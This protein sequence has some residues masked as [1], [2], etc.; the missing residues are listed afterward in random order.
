MGKEIERKFLVNDKINKVLSKVNSKHCSQTYLASD[1]EKVV[2]VRILGK[3]GFLTIKSKVIGI[4]R[5]EF[6][7]EIPLDEANKMIDLFGV[8]VI[9]KK[10][11]LIPIKN[12]TWEVDVFEG[13][14]KGLIIAEIELQSEDE[15]FDIPHWILKEVTGDVKY[16]NNNLQKHPYSSWLKER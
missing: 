3:K 15:Q 6:E 5:H 1:N 10:R 8:Q 9:E 7:Y 4:S 2:R 12:H 13:V 14:N 11:Y 16:Y